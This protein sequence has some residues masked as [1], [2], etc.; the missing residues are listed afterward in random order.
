MELSTEILT[1]WFGQDLNAFTDNLFWFDCSVDAIITEK[2]KEYVD[3]PSINIKDV[4]DKLTWIIIGDQFT[5]NIYRHDLIQRTKNDKWVLDLVLDMLEKNEDLTLNLNMRLFILL[6]LRHQKKSNLLNIVIERVKMYL[7]E[8][9]LNIPSILTKFYAHSIKNYTYLEDEINVIEPSLDETITLSELIQT[10]KYSDI[11]DSSVSFNDELL[12]IKNKNVIFNCIYEWLRSYK[13]TDI[14]IGVSLSGGVD[15]M[16]FLSILYQIKH[17]KYNRNLI[18]NIIAIHIE[19]TNR[20]EAIIERDFLIDFCNILGIKF[21]YRTI[22]YMHRTTENID[23]AIYEIESKKLRFNLYKYAV[24]HE[25]LI[26]IC[27]GHHMGDVV[28]N[29]LTNMIKGKSIENLGMMKEID[30]QNDVNIFRPMLEQNKKDIFEYAL[31]FGIPYFKNSTPVWSCR[32]V[33]RDEVIPK[34]KDQFGEFE[35][36]MIIMAEKCKTMYSLGYKYAIE[37]Y[38]SSIV[39]FKYGI[40][41]DYN[42]DFNLDI[43][44]DIILLE[45][46][47]SNGY[48]MISSKSKNGFI[49]WLSSLGSSQYE[50]C[51]SHFAYYDKYIY[52]I[53]FDKIKSKIV[54]NDLECILNDG[55]KTD[56]L[57]LLPNK[58]KKL[59]F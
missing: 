11:L 20:E 51:S 49:K 48:P 38:I 56:R 13:Q 52:I 18:G 21:Y 35:S 6:P 32:G 33:I 43:V 26:G 29:V 10:K 34:L 55:I 19:H 14:N 2:Y 17:S 28:E 53:D 31:E 7:E 58:L 1:F 36:N 9:K 8:F 44:W 5:R 12:N 42:N 46:F 3:N 59:L 39:K 54:I 22:H 24:E 25:K 50:L 4:Y 27:L 16:V 23:R 57:V 37:P 45:Y 40:R 41:I 47:H 30:F 15:S